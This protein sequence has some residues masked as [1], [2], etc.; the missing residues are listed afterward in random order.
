VGGIRILEVARTGVRYR[1]GDKAVFAPL[2]VKRLNV[3]VA[4]QENTR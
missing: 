2:A 1:Q 3:K 4:A